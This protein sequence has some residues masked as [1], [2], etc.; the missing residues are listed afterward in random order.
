MVQNVLPK[1]SIKIF[2]FFLLL[3][4][5][6]VLYYTGVYKQLSFHNIKENL[7][8]IQLYY[9]ERPLIF[10]S[11]FLLLYILITALSIP[12]AIVLT[13]LSGAIYGVLLGTF[14]V[15]VA[16]CIGATIA[17]YMSRYF[18]RDFF[19]D[20]YRNRFEDL[21]KKFKEG[22]KTYLFTMR[23]IPVSP[24]VI[25]NLLMGLT[26]IDVWTYIWVTFLGMIPGTVMYV[27]A[28][29]RISEIS[30]PGDILD[31]PLLLTF[32]LIGL[33]PVVLKYFQKGKRW[34]HA[35]ES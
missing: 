2:L 6:I 4:L 27:F 13:L 31:W 35:H 1:P 29:R 24:F 34:N 30:S 3:C 5:L 8:A 23:L 18:F 25:I 7:D 26:S 22:G 15:S 14:I 19:L 10:T 16:S 12:G 21:D 11:I 33:L 9:S 20:K 28:G 17:F 32:S